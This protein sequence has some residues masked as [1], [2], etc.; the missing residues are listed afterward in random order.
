MQI[1]KLLFTCF[2]CGSGAIFSETSHL[3]NI[4][5]EVVAAHCHSASCISCC[6]QSLHYLIKITFKKISIC[7]R[8]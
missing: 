3:M 7:K 4:N 5:T 1:R 8:A 2:P 6:H